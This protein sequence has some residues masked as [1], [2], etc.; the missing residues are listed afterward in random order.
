MKEETM[1]KVFI[2]LIFS[3]G[4]FASQAHA[5]TVPPVVAEGCAAHCTPFPAWSAMP[6]VGIGLFVVYA[7]AEGI[8]FPLCG[9]DGLQCFYEYPSD[10]K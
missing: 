2:G 10:R 6:A 4:L 8:P 7:N 9:F 5:Q 3:L 1:R